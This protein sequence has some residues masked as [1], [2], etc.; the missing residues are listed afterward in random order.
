MR[1][2]AALLMHDAELALE[3]ASARTQCVF[4]DRA[5][6]TD[7][8]Q[9]VDHSRVVFEMVKKVPGWWW[10]NIE[11]A[12]QRRRWIE[13]VLVVSKER[14]AGDLDHPAHPRSSRGG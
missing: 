8:G 11:L 10:Y 7:V 6:G 9:V 1:A 2:E 3:H 13:H 5:L 12:R 14:Y 4:A